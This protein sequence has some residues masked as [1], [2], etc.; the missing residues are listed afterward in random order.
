MP[1]AHQ[2]MT[3]KIK[4]VLKSVMFWLP[5]LEACPFIYAKYPEGRF[6]KGPFLNPQHQNWILPFFSPDT[7]PQ[8][9]PWL[10]ATLWPSTSWRVG[11][12]FLCMHFALHKFEN[13]L[14][15]FLKNDRN[16]NPKK[17]WAIIKR[18]LEYTN[19]FLIMVKFNLVLLYHLKQNII[20]ERLRTPASP[21]GV[22]INASS[23]KKG[24]DSTCP[25]TLPAPSCSYQFYLLPNLDKNFLLL[26]RPNIHARRN[27]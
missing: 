11:G 20:A 3:I 8:S 23:S 21:M 24:K 16:N 18:H 19:C 2:G 17:K 12:C 22:S 26:T 1:K 7:L 5:S 14:H 9:K 15:E 4:R 10:L 25:Y 27:A 13:V 6:W